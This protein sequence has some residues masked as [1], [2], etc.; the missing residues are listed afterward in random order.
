MSSWVG[1]SS[2]LIVM[3]SFLTRFIRTARALPEL[4]FTLAG[5]A[6]FYASRPFVP[7]DV[8]SLVGWNINAYQVFALLTAFLIYLLP[9]F[10]F[11]RGVRVGGSW[12]TRIPTAFAA[13]TGLWSIPGL[14]VAASA[15]LPITALVYSGLIL[16]GL[17]ALA[18]FFREYR[19][20]A[21]LTTEDNAAAEGRADWGR[22][23][24]IGLAAL[25]LA[26]LGVMTWVSVN[27]PVSNDDNLQLMYTQD[28]L[29]APHINEFE[30][31]FGIDIHP[32]TRGSLTTWPVNLT[33]FAFFSGLAAQQSFWILRTVLV[34]INVLSFYTLNLRFFGKRNHA[35]LATIIY[36]LIAFIFTTDLDGVGF[37]M[38]ARTAQDKFVVR[39]ALLPVALAWSL[40]YL[41][42]PRR[43]VYWLAGLIIY[44]Q[45]TTHVVGPVLLAFPLGGLG[46]LHIINHAQ[47]LDWALLWPARWRATVRVGWDAFKRVGVRGAPGAF[48]RRGWELLALNWPMLQPFALLAIFPV[49]TL[50]LPLAAQAS[51]DA[52]VVAYSLIDTRDPSLFFRVS[53]AVNNY[54]LLINNAFGE[55]AY[56]VHPRVFLSSIILVPML[57]FP[58]MWWK[59]RKRT[60]TEMIIGAY[61]LNPVVLL[62]PPIIQFLG[63]HSTPWLL[64]RFA[65]G[66]SLLGP[67]VLGWAAWEAL[68]FISAR[69][70]WPSVRAALPAAA[71]IVAGLALS[72]DINTGLTYLH[73][74]RI[75][76]ALSRCRTLQPV[77]SKLKVSVGNGAT[78]LAT[79]DLDICMPSSIA[80][81]YPVEYGLSST[82]NRFPAS[83]LSEGKQRFYDDFDFTK[84][85]VV[86]RDFMDILTRWNVGFL[87]LREDSPL[88]GQLRHM[89]RFF[90]L[91]WQEG[92]YRLYRVRP[93]MGVDIQLSL[94]PRARWKQVSWA[95]DDPMIDANSLW[96]DAKWQEAIDAYRKLEIAPGADT[97]TRYLALMGEAQALQSSGRL[98]EAIAAY[99][100]AVKVMPSDTGVQIL[101]GNAYWLKGDYALSA[102]ANEAAVRITNWNPVAL[103][104]LGVLYHLLGRDAD[105]RDALIRYS[106]VDYAPGTVNYYRALG[107]AYLSANMVD[108]AIA[109]FKKSND[110]RE[111]TY[112]Y[113]YLAQA[114]TQQ[115]KLAE[116]R[117]AGSNG[118]RVEIWDDLPYVSLGAV[119]VREGKSDLAI[120]HLKKAVFRDPQSSG[121]T[122]LI[123]TVA[124]SQGN[125]AALSTVKKQVGYRLGF[126]V[127]D[128][129]AAQAELA[130]G[131][132][133]TAL[134]L[135][136]QSFQW[137]LTNSPAG[138]FL[139]NTE[140][141][142]GHDDEAERYFSEAIRLYPYNAQAYMGRSAVAQARGDWG[143]A[144]GWAWSGMTASPYDSTAVTA[145]GN[146][147]AG[148]GDPATALLTYQRASAVVPTDP[149][150]YLAA[151][152]LYLSMG[153]SPEHLAAL[154]IPAVAVVCGSCKLASV[155]VSQPALTPYDYASDPAAGAKAAYEA[156][157]QLETQSNLSYVGLGNLALASGDLQSGIAYYEKA[158]AL[159]PFDGDSL[160]SLGN[161]YRQ[162]GRIDDAVKT[163][164]MAVQK[165]PG[166]IN[167]YDSLGNFYLSRAQ[168]QQATDTFEQAIKQLPWKSNG[169]VNLGNLLET[170]GQNDD[171]RK[172]YQAATNLDPREAASA[173]G[174]LAQL[175]ETQG[176][177]RL[178]EL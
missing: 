120:N 117:Q 119:D 65:W 17:L 105:A 78:V 72:H 61:V 59:A 35:I 28:N 81:A 122:S 29:V 8:I 107:S 70:S 137:N 147:Y 22:P 93:G 41:R 5:A 90:E 53:L 69:V 99:Q 145:L 63:S 175:A 26:A 142:L 4:W 50:V 110:I 104:R 88:D 68:E 116:A 13:A 158:V 124:Y 112:A 66:L 57:F 15:R 161:V 165:D 60:A 174:A 58:L 51:P 178:A 56:I 12:L 3:S 33:L 14:V 74:V 126:S 79:F 138:V 131:D 149:G 115:N 95:G 125:E 86:D 84:A 11:L 152:K 96:T 23:L 121:L 106:S 21:N 83:R 133:I 92:R 25:G 159:S 55:G 108:D 164:L 163:L 144:M 114:Y 173:Q 102:A 157:S 19:S 139:G 27:A 64:Y 82:I 177:Y 85:Q 154:N 172:Q 48:W 103:Q 168:R 37:G 156:A 162:A 101:L 49:A 30:P 40:A 38:F 36:C 9:G 155:K 87:L 97:N 171:A 160:V 167:A 89:P 100:A 10:M 113:Y 1:R 94:P 118:Q 43:S 146:L 39:Y 143:V 98:D 7:A 62:T 153:Q 32:N 123:A 20:P 80:K 111:T 130:M 45:G 128:L 76:P 148:E 6:S 166:Y 176:D 150:P 42:Q 75:D 132:V 91:Q 136:E 2:L 140:H 24:N 67:I 34:I 54:R 151:G 46:V 44:G 71:L 52:P 141:M 134:K 135:G 127:A 16:T 129:A 170:L 109:I 77:F 47:G 169:Y 31:I 18:A 73:Q